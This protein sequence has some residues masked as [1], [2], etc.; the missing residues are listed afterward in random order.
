MSKALGIT[1]IVVLV[2]ALAGG[3]FFAG[4]MVGRFFGFGRTAAPSYGWYDS[5]GPGM[6][7]RSGGFGT[8]GGRGGYGMMGGYGYN[9]NT[10][11]PTLTVD[12]A[13][14]AAQKYLAALN[15]SDLAI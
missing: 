6:M 11:L 4:A 12:Q 2:L 10:N 7:G 15:N 9:N 14:T 1:L 13:R 5:Y 3:L 8:M